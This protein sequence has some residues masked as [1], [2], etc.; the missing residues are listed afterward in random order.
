MT[1]DGRQKMG[2]NLG[3]FG[4][5]PL[6]FGLISALIGFVLAFNRV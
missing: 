3:L 1:E 6:I 4:F 5:V 2:D